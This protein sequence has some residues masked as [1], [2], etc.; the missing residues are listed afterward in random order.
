LARDGGADQTRKIPVAVVLEAQSQA[1]PADGTIDEGQLEAQSLSRGLPARDLKRESAEAEHD[2]DQKF[3]NHF[4]R[5][6]VWTVYILYVGFL[7]FSAVWIIHVLTPWG[8][9]KPPELDKVQGLLTGGAIAGLLADHVRKR[10][11]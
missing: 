5:L 1:V 9:L 2:R 7:A 6:A 10:M 4:E 11:S 3:K 8:W